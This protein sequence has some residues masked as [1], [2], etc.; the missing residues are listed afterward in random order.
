MFKRVEQKDRKRNAWEVV[1]YLIETMSI[2]VVAPVELFSA[3]SSTLKR[4]MKKTG[5]LSSNL[6]IKSMMRSR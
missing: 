3:S 4:H 5:M 1:T 6:L 2:A